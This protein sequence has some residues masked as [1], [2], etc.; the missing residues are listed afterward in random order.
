MTTRTNRLPLL[1]AALLLTAGAVSA[2]EPTVPAAP[3]PEAV[4]T[5]APA[6]AGDGLSAAKV[7]M[8][9]KTHELRALTAAEDAE[10]EAQMKAFWGQFST[11]PH[12]VKKDRKTGKLSYTVAPTHMRATMVRIGVDGKPVYD[13]FD[14][15]T[16]VSQAMTELEAKAAAQA[17]KDEE[18]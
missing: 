17:T 11:V 5:P 2:S 15:N 6:P 13:C 4:A 7:A 12:T 16:S 14:A 9:P 1:A 3:A 18:Q 8:D 10:L